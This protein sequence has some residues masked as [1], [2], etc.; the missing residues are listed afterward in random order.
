M[1]KTVEVSSHR[2]ALTELTVF[3]QYDDVLPEASILK[4]GAVSSCH[5]A[6]TELTVFSQYEV[7]LPEAG[8]LKLGALRLFGV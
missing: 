5:P 2:P 7:V 8:I 3:F 4:T 1:L 6:L